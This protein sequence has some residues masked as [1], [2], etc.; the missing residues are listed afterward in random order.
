MM[1]LYF[2]NTSSNSSKK[3]IIKKNEQ[4]M[5]DNQKET[6]AALDSIFGKAP[7]AAETNSAFRREAVSALQVGNADSSGMLTLRMAQNVFDCH[8]LPMTEERLMA[9]LNSP[10][11]K[12]KVELIR[13]GNEKLKSR[14]TLH[15]LARHPRHA[16]ICRRGETAVG[17]C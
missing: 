8:P 2:K 14:T 12:A 7:S 11:T 16:P 5:V 13:K 17:T 4:T 3:K 1:W 9:A 6:D 10:N 15:L